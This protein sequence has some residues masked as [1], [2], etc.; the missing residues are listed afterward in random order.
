MR[1]RE[2]W[3]QLK[4]LELKLKQA[5]GK[6]GLQSS[7]LKEQTFKYGRLKSLSSKLEDI[8]EGNIITIIYQDEESQESFRRVFTNITPIDAEYY[9]KL[10][11]NMQGRKIRILECRDTPTKNSV[12]KL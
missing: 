12:T 6:P 8:I 10:L 4:L 1:I 9:L 3:D 5:K 7:L 2:T 11:A